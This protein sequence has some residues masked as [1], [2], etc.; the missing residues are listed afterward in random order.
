MAQCSRRLALATGGL[1]VRSRA[2]IDRR[3]ARLPALAGARIRLERER[4][5][6]KGARLRALDPRQVLRRGFAI[7]RD[8]SGRI[9]T[10]VTD[11]AAGDEIGIDLRDGTLGAQL[12][13]VD[14]E[15]T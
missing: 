13:R 3:L 5:A 2:E 6:S 12:T 4:V 10:S 8:G 15:G 1:V 9:R 14:R 11:L 7:V